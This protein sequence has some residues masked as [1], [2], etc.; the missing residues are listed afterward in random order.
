M[1]IKCDLA[2]LPEQRLLTVAL[3]NSVPCTQRV[4]PSLLHPQSSPQVSAAS[5][6]RWEMREVQ[7]QNSP[8]RQRLDWN[9]VPPLPPNPHLSDSGLP[10]REQIQDLGM[11]WQVRPCLWLTQALTCIREG[12]QR[13][14]KKL[15]KSMLHVCPAHEIELIRG[16]P[17][18][19]RCLC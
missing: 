1:E 19:S 10:P 16:Q 11:T 15:P 14:A 4:H 7:Q 17:H 8:W 18:S 12:E 13:F 5:L 3:V 2:A 6:D 9:P